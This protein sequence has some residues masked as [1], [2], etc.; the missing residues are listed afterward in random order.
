[1]MPLPSKYAELCKKNFKYPPKFVVWDQI[2]AK[3]DLYIFGMRK[4]VFKY[5][6]YI[7]VSMGNLFQS[8]N[9]YVDITHKNVIRWFVFTISCY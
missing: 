7:T 3:K 8:F 9:I 2:R 4:G 1:M 5:L 6:A